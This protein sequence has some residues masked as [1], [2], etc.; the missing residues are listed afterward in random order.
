M[1]KSLLDLVYYFEIHL[2]PRCLCRR[3]SVGSV[4]KYEA[5][6]VGGGLVLG[7]EAGGSQVEDVWKEN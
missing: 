3:H 4:L 2:H 6:R 5:V 1:R 7:G